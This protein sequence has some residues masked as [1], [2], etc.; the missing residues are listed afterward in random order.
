MVMVCV[1]IL[2]FFFF[3][4][5]TAY[6]MRISDWSSDVCSSDLGQDDARQRAARRNGVG[7]CAGHP[8]RRHPRTAMPAP[9]Y[10][11]AAYQVGRCV[12]DRPRSLD[13]DRKSVVEGKRVSVR[14]DLG[15]RRI[16]KK[17]NK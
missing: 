16:L 7:R 10:G 11:C 14:V 2:L 17:K 9:G 4:Q 1:D 13:K 15:G 6:E 12:D 3:R 5:K 8:H